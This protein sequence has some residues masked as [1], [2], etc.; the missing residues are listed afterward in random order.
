[1]RTCSVASISGIIGVIVTDRQFLGLFQSLFQPFLFRHSRVP[2]DTH[3][4]RTRSDA[5]I[6]PA[7]LGPL[8]IRLMR[9]TAR[10]HSHLIR[11]VRI[12]I[13]RRPDT[14]VSTK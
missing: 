2:L 14:S 12:R 3:Y 11:C 6:S 7:Y 1:M 4:L 13:V 8:S 10:L 9:A 5:A